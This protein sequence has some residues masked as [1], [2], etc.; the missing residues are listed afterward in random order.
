[1][2]GDLFAQSVRF[3]ELDEG[4]FT[5]DLGLY[6]GLAAQWGGPILELGCGNGRVLQTLAAAGYEAVGVDD[7]AA[8][9]QAAQARLGR[10]AKV[11]LVA[12]DMRTFTVDERFAWAFFAMNSFMHLPT[13]EEQL[14]ALCQARRHLRKG[15]H[16]A[17][18][19]TNPDP[20]W[21]LE[22]HERIVRVGVLEDPATGSTVIR[23][24]IQRTDPLRQTLY[25]TYIY[26]EV[27]PAGAVRR[28][29][30]PMQ[31]RYLFPYEARLLL[32]RAGFTVEEIYG[33][34]EMDPFGGTDERMI[35]ICRSA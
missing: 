1:M 20:G 18:D 11:R 35:F 29:L 8:M 33:S 23:Q 21:L 24:V 30:C 26:D 7:S 34:Y 9:L 19:L 10:V 13:L 22:P 31:L 17:L 25:L 16:L 32:E 2:A 3:Y 27:G 5:D 15:G 4:Q 12:G 6:A 28:V 14:A